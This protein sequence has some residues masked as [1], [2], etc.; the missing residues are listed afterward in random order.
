MRTSDNFFVQFIQSILEI[1]LK[2]EQYSIGTISMVLWFPWGSEPSSI[3]STCVS[4]WIEPSEDLRVATA[5]SPNRTSRGPEEVQ[6]SFGPETIVLPVPMLITFNVRLQSY[7]CP[8]EVSSHSTCLNPLQWR[9][10]PISNICSSFFNQ[11][12]RVNTT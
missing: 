8:V 2:V 6:R 9:F 11:F 4:W 1:S 10:E 7:G 12:G 3:S 5:C